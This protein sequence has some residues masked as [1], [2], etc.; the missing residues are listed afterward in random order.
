M[1]R[2]A[3]LSWAEPIQ[4]CRSQT[5]QKFFAAFFQKKKTFLPLA[6]ARARYLGS[7]KKRSKKLLIISASVL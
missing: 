5:D 7:D 1:L 2:L 4:A 6:L 3:A